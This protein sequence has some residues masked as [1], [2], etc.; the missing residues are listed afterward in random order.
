MSKQAGKK[1]GR[2]E[3]ATAA[4]PVHTG[5]EAKAMLSAV[6]DGKTGR[7]WDNVVGA[8]IRV[9]QTPGASH[10]VQ[11][12]LTES[13]RLSGLT[14]KHLEAVTMT[15]NAD[16]DFMV[17]YIS[18]CLMPE[19]ALVG[20]TRAAATI[21]L[22]DVIAAVGWNPQST[23]QR[24]EQRRRVWDFIKFVARAEI[25]GERTGKYFDKAT[26]EAIDT[27]MQSP[28]W[29]I[30]EKQFEG[31]QPSLFDDPGD[32]VP[33][34]VELVASREWTKI[35]TKRDIAQFLPMGEVLG[36][37]PGGRP[38]G[39]WA[40]VIGLVLC[41]FWRRS[42]S[43]K[44]ARKDLLTTY[45]PATG[46]VSDVLESPNPRRALEYW[47]GALR[48]LVERGFIT[49]AGEALVTYEEQR[50]SVTGRRW[51]E[52]WMETTVDITPGPAMLQTLAEL[53]GRRFK[54]AP[55]QLGK[56]RRKRNK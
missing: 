8:D 1:A 42:G 44:P 14:C 22:D 19:T 35:T 25:Y 30:E 7:Y 2:D 29:M 51:Q 36:A 37:I 49:E 17:L 11:I 43:R 18:R 33:L 20:N 39:A 16:E 40:R 55:K 41:D 54:A 27:Y 28:P 6:S 48:I 32:P 46:A 26:G 23:E 4:F 21:D 10:R 52:E 50:D 56:P 45:P 9:H 15:R 5:Q 38:A 12:A 31:K 13:E 53:D 24:A 3:S 34:T 47:A